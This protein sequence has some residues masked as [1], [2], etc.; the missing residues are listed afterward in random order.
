MVV[1]ITYDIQTLDKPGQRRLR[2]I[3]KA[4][5]S[6]GQRVQFS[7]FECMLTPALWTELRGKLLSTFDPKVDS[8]RFYFLGEDDVRQAE[9]HGTKPSIDF[10]G[11]L[12]L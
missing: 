3:A 9:H 2:R 12:V 7:V 10:E 5:V 4:C 11:P 8:L 1:L 6:C